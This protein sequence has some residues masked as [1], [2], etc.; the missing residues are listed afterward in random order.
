M[1]NNIQRIFD[2]LSS[3]DYLCHKLRP[4][5]EMICSNCYEVHE[6]MCAWE[7]GNGE[8]GYSACSKCGSFEEPY[9]ED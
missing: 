7:Y 8:I 2:E 5:G 3:E 4:V 9:E 1:A 6:W